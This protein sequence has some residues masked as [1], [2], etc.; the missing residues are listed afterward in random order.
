MAAGNSG[1][2]VRDNLPVV[3]HVVNQ[4]A[5]RYP[6]HVDRH[7][8]WSAGALGLV[9]AARRYDPT[10]GIPF[11]RYASIRIRGAIIDASRDRDW[12]PRSL[13]RHARDI[14]AAADAL[15]AEHSRRPTEAELAARLELTAE[16]LRSRQTDLVHARILDLDR[17]ADDGEPGCA[18]ADSVREVDG[19]L[20]PDVALERRELVGALRLAVSLLP[21][22]HRQI[23][24]RYYFGG[25]LLRDIAADRKVTEAR[26]SQ[27]CLE[28]VQAIRAYFATVFED[29][30]EVSDK[31]PGRQRRDAYV[32][33]MRARTTWRDHFAAAGR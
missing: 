24:E 17:E 6:R 8:L 1:E 19:D 2:L 22:L 5:A 31:M 23:I 10:M 32:A 12:A 20:L 11:P 28:G 18:L 4:L 14:Q 16:E 9:D 7:E 30:P 33:S 29:V 15:E 13:R 3:Q 26:I 25:E 27:M 21:E